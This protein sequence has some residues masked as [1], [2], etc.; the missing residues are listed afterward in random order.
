M[1]TLDDLSAIYNQAPPT[2]FTLADIGLKSDFAAQDAEIGQKRLIRNF[3]QRQLPRM[4]SNQAARGAYDTSA[5][6]RKTENLTEDFGD[7]LS[8][9]AAA[10]GRTQANLATNALLA[11]TGIRL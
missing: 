7:N 6:V 8:D 10:G 1:A 5:T 3:G 4:V 2:G 9:L 11:M